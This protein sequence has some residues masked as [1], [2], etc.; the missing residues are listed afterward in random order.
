MKLQ[1]S[2]SCAI[3]PVSPFMKSKHALAREKLGKCKYDEL[4]MI[5]VVPI[6]LI[7]EKEMLTEEKSFSMSFASNF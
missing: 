5:S 6:F 3:T 1:I 7:D 4:K 2:S